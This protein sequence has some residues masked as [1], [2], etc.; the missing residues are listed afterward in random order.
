MGT[1][2]CIKWE[3][4]NGSSSF[5]E[6][7]W[8][9]ICCAG[10]CDVISAVRHAATHACRLQAVD[11]FDCLP[12]SCLTVTPTFDAW[13][14]VSGWRWMYV[15]ACT[16]WVTWGHDLTAVDLLSTDIAVNVPCRLS[17]LVI[18]QRQFV[19]ESC[20]HKTFCLTAY[21]C[22]A[23]ICC[24]SWLWCVLSARWQ[25]RCII[26]NVH[27]LYPIR[28]SHQRSTTERD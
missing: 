14:I 11:T 17:A 26:R 13:F 28:I 22:T 20:V 18:P 19:T 7:L 8:V 9:S 6:S 27:N 5:S 4:K 15:G 2:C 21:A 10:A 24:L 12:V 23:V 3:T 16:L 1:Y 25:R